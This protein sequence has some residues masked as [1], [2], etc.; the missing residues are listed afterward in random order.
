MEDDLSLVNGLSF[1]LKKWGFSPDVART[2]L[3]AERL[4]EDGTYD[5]LVLDVALPDGSGFAFCKKVRQKGYAVW[6]LPTR[7]MNYD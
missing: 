4:W 2:L 6:R 1:A 3:E 5:L 7:S